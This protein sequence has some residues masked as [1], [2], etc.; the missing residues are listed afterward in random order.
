MKD[1]KVQTSILM[2]YLCIIFII[3]FKVQFF[4]HTSII[5]LIGQK[6]FVIV[7]YLKD[8]RKIQLL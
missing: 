8:L 6:T 7:E 1:N 2:Y 5:S 3:V 4:K